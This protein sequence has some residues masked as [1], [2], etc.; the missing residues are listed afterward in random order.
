MTS[1]TTPLD[2][3]GG[4]SNVWF[5]VVFGET[6]FIGNVLLLLTSDFDIPTP[7]VTLL[8][9]SNFDIVLLFLGVLDKAPSFDD[10]A[11]LVVKPWLL[12]FM[13]KFILFIVIFFLCSRIVD[14]LGT[15]GTV[16]IFFFGFIFIKAAV[17]FMDF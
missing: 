3:S 13:F 5:F 2:G 1:F 12:F 4:F 10:G 9:V 11:M 6:S 16:K 14:S 7:F 8:K 15:K 17:A